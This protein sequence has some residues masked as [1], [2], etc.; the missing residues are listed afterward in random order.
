MLITITSSPGLIGNQM[1]VRQLGLGMM[2]PWNCFNVATP[3]SN[4]AGASVQRINKP[5][6]QASLPA[7][8]EGPMD[9]IPLVCSH[10]N[11]S[12]AIVTTRLLRMSIAMQDLLCSS[13]H[14]LLFCGVS[15][16]FLWSHLCLW[17]VI[18]DLSV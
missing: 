1:L 11:R 15:V 3:I 7:W 12:Y 2:L 6:S 5:T 14:P 16:V 13:C 17:V 18:C 10:Q 4:H 9:S 8:F